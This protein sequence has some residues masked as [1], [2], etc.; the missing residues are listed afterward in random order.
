MN[1]AKHNQRVKDELKK[2]GMTAY[3]FT[4][5]STGYLPTII[6]ENE[7][8]KGVV[9]GRLYESFEPVMLVATDRR[10]IFIDCKPFYRNWD[11]ITYEVVAGVKTT[12]AGPFASIVLHTHVKDY[13]L[14]YVNIKCAKKFVEYIEKYIEKRDTASTLK[15]EEPA[16]KDFQPYKIDHDKPLSRPHENDGT[17]K[18]DNTAVLST[19]D[20][21]GN[22]HAS[23]IHYILDKDENIYFLTKT[24]TTKVKNL[25]SNSKVQITIHPSESLQV[26][27]IKGTA[28][29]IADAKLKQQ[30][31]EHII[32]PRK[33]IEGTKLPPIA[34]L[35]KGNYI[36]YKVTATDSNYM[37][38]SEQSW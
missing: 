14:R 32:E 8:V 13:E 33:Y 38:Y 35:D 24:E 10:V 1:L 7:H 25:E 28:E 17:T 16:K 34:K 5:L 21:R 37:D 30:V 15:P 4:K 26:L 20:G 11:E 9:Y 36:A 23:V 3:G 18:L 31:F 22:V 2:A 12:L 6:H 19:S 27:Y 29:P